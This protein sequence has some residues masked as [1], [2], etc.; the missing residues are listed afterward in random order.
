MSVHSQPYLTAEDYLA[1]ERTAETK[2]EYL[3]GEIVAIPGASNEHNL[4]VVNVIGELRQQ[5]KQRPWLLYPSDMRVR[6][7]ATGL[8]TYPDVVVVCGEPCFEDEK[9]DILLNPSLIIEVLSPSTESYDRGKKFEHYRT[10]E[11]LAEYVLVAQEEPRV[12][13]FVRQPGGTWLFT[14]T[15]GR[16]AVVH[17]PSLGCSLALAEIYDKVPLP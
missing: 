6:V 5:L 3:D 1:Y 7:S 10:L 2:S 4:I 15:S 9:R 16:D 17:L 14:A 12:E 11:S 8:Y 13:Q